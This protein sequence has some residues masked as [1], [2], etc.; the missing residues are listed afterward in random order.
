MRLQNFIVKSLL[1]FSILIVAG[2]VSTTL[3]VYEDI[4]KNYIL[5]PIVD[6]DNLIS[7]EYRKK[8]LSSPVRIKI[9]S[10][11]VNADVEHVGLA[12]NGSMDV[13]QNPM[14]VA[15][16]ESGVRPGEVGSSVMNGH[17]G[18]KNGKKVVFDD[19]YK[20]KKGDKVYVI[21]G[22]GDTVT[23]LVRE[24]KNYDRNADTSEVFNSGDGLS[25][26][27]L[28]TCAGDWN[29]IAKTHDERLV[30]FTDLID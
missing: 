3:L 25:H 23:F 22:E 29:A 13:P 28:I 18:Y 14:N 19:L 6:Q 15:W 9:P 27:N 11:G 20:L 12:T 5:T 1:I 21:D 4:S 30:V 26:L 7:T 16:F 10:I 17:T 24:L 2:V 8:S